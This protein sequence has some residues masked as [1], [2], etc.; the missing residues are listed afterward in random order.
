MSSLSVF[1]NQALTKQRFEMILRLFMLPAMMVSLSAF[2]FAVPVVTVAISPT[3]V[4]IPISGNRQLTATVSGTANTAVIWSVN[5]IVGGNSTLGTIDSTGKYFAPLL[6]PAGYN[7]TV[8]AV[9]VADP[10]ASASCA[11]QVRYPLPYLTSIVPNPLGTGPFT[12]TVNGSRFYSGAQVLWNGTPLTTNYVSATQLTATGNAA[13]P[14]SAIITVANPGPASVSTNLTLQVS[15]GIIITLTPPAVSLQPNATQQFQAAV[16]GT[17]NQAVIWQVNGITGGSATSGTITTTGFYTAP[18]A[19]PSGAVTVAAV[20]QADNFSNGQATVALKNPLLL[21]FGRF[22]EQASF[23]PTQQSLTYAQQIGMQAWLSEQFII[24]EATYPDY[25]AN[26]TASAADAFF[27]NCTMGSDQLRQRSIYA[28]S[29]IIVVSSNKAVAANQMIPWMQLL[30]RNSF[31]NYRQLL[32]EVTLDPTMGFYLDLANSTEGGGFT[33]NENYPRE[34]MQL[35]SLGL[36]LLNP[37]GSYQLDA[38]NQRIPTYTQT[39][40]RNLALALTGWTNPT[41]AG[42]PMTA[43]NFSYSPGVMEA[44]EARHDHRAKVVLGQSLPAN[45]TITQDLDGSIDIIFNHPNLGPF[46]ATRLIRALVMSNPSPAYIQ[47]ITTVFNNNGQGVRGDL[48]ATIQAILLDQEARQ[49]TPTANSGKLRSPMLHGIS[50]LRAFGGQVGQGGTGVSWIYGQMGE[51][52][53]SPNSVF[54]HYSPMFRIPGQQLFGPEF[55]IYSPTEAVNRANYLY[56]IINAYNGTLILPFSNL[57][58]D[59]VALVDLIDSTFLYGRMS[60]AMRTSLYTAIQAQPDNRSKAAA[61]IY[62]TVMSGDYLVM[63]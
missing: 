5:N 36:Y 38:Q 47:R 1:T 58:S 39:D 24:A 16:S 35:F 14:G 9:S 19:P 52:I 56:S 55:Q 34:A 28:L 43:Y 22:L 30:S 3:S 40:V 33:A 11:V 59:P 41:P 32:R 17:N 62:L 21:T 51:A 45:Q 29:Q 15:S 7:V 42:Q 50:F 48:K 18:S 31:G 4:T 25:V 61:A 10:T 63:H 37:D 27:Y 26:P 44:R 49:D 54:S 46:V 8:K 53:L 2:A 23:G 13:Q 20:S 12:L 60:A 57:A 6:P